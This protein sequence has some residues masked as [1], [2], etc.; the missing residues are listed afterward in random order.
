L[1]AAAPSALGNRL[2]HVLLLLLLQ[3]SVILGM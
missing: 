3:P 1:F 2:V